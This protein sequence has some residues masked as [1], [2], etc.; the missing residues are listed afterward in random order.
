MLTLIGFTIGFE[1][2]TRSRLF[3]RK[4]VNQE[5]YKLYLASEEILEQRYR[6]SLLDKCIFDIPCTR[7]HQGSFLYLDILCVDF[8]FH[9]R[10]VGADL[11]CTGQ[12]LASQNNLSIRTETT[13]NNLP[14][15]TR[16]GF[17]Q[18]GE[19]E[20]QTPSGLEPML[21]S[22]LSWTKPTA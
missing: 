17:S 20:V 18:D 14:F 19:W 8:R 5:R 15:Y 12:G 4:D 13:H 10:G 3:P 6:I 1:L 21:L 7:H 22:L 2:W 16:L 11:I 9:R